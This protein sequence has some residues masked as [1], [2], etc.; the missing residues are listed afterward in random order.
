V[1]KDLEDAEC[2][3]KHRFSESNLINSKTVYDRK[4]SRIAG[5]LGEI[6]FKKM[7]P[8]AVKSKD[9]TYDFDVNGEKVDVKCKYRTVN[10]KQE[11]EASFFLYQAGEKFNANLYFFM[12]TIPSFE[13]VW[14][15][16]YLSKEDILKDPHTEIWKQGQIDENNGMTFKEDTICLKYKY[17]NRI[18]L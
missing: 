11:F 15:C 12:S 17:L 5:I 10:P 8:N 13:Y 2:E 4:H 1:P 18:E 6:I 3:F 7:Y 9:I 14:L 16:G